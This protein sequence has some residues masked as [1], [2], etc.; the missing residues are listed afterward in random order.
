MIFE[1]ALEPQLLSSWSNFQ[2][3][4]GLFGIPN[5]RLISRYP[6]RWAR[7]VYDS[8][9][10]GTTEKAKI[11]I[12]LKRVEREL[13]LPRNHQWDDTSDWLS[14]A[15]NE[16]VRAPFHALLASN[17]SSDCSLVIDA[18]DLDCTDLPP[19][20]KAGPRRIVTRNAS[21]L[22]KALRPLLLLSERILIVEPNFTI[23]SRR[24]RDPLEAI[25]LAALDL[26]EK[27][28]TTCTIELHLGMDKLDD[29]SDKTAALDSF[30]S[31][32][33]PESM[34]ISVVGWHKDDLHNRFV[35]TDCF[36]IMLGEGLGLPDSRSS[37]TDDVLALL[38]VATANELMS[39]YGNTG[40]HRLTHRVVGTKRIAF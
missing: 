36:G 24:F 37:R 27:V 12:A 34:S 15:I 6:K 28:R 1:Y 5:G 7:L 9:P 3:L 30:L 4:V 31:P 18:T 25:V 11:E 10:S 40:K 8:V 16:H 23:K 32:H 13:L 22:G 20:L 29:Y 33:I 35:V 14:N 39:R 19:L 2:R 17:S 21:E 26:Q 38:E